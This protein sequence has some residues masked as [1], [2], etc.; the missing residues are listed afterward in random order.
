VQRDMGALISD[1][2]HDLDEQLFLQQQRAQFLILQQQLTE[3]RTLQQLG[4]AEAGQGPAG[5]RPVDQPGLRVSKIIR[6]PAHLHAKTVTL[7]GAGK[8][9]PATVDFVLD[10]TAAGHVTVH[11]SATLVL[12]KTDTWAF[13]SAAWSS[14]A[15]PFE[16]GLVQH[17]SVECGVFD[18]AVS[19]DPLMEPGLCHW[20]LLVE[21]RAGPGDAGPVGE[22]PLEATTVEW[23]MCRIGEPP[24]LGYSLVEVIQQQVAC[25]RLPVLDTFEVFGSE[26]GSDGRSRQDCIVC[27]CEPRDTMVLP[28]RHM[29]LC[30]DCSEYIRTRVQYTSY[31]CPICRKRISRMMRLDQAGKPKGAASPVN[32]PNQG[33][34]VVVQG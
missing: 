15:I 8:G 21:L 3:A 14:E 10:A 31:K 9:L 16:A 4:M 7:T 19:Q 13:E 6:N 33:Q 22:A 32:F 30:S 12:D 29:C 27:Q 28:C 1:E 34:A 11:R 5:M 23:T 26:L 20:P 18:E 24:H 17:I 2:Q 25:S